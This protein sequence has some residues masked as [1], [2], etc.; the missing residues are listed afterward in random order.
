MFNNI[1]QIQK[2]TTRKVMFFINATRKV[3]FMYHKKNIHTTRKVMFMFYEIS[4]IYEYSFEFVNKF[5]LENKINFKLKN[6]LEDS[7]IENLGF[8]KYIKRK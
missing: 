8:N 7:I 2:N 6:V 3:M 1:L 4:Y 5:D